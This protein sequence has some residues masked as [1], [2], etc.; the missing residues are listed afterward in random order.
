MNKD[1][2][3]ESGHRLKWRMEAKM[4]GPRVPIDNPLPIHPRRIIFLFLEFFFSH[5]PPFSPIWPWHTSECNVEI[6]Y[7]RIRDNYYEEANR[8]QAAS[9]A[10]IESRDKIWEIF[11]DFWFKNGSNTEETFYILCYWC[12]YW[13]F[14]FANR[15]I[16]Q[17]KV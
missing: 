11:Q 5:F 15:I 3:S 2:N 9:W 4:G 12:T 1:C 8:N 17:E 13:I 14:L 16:W 10:V 7:F 6:N